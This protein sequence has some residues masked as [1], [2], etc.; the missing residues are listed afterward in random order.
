ENVAFPLRRHTQMSREEREKKARELL[1]S[2]GMED[3]IS[4]MPSEL[5]GGMQRRVGLARAL[6]LDP[7]M[8]LSDEPTAGLGP[9]TA[10]EIVDLIAEQKKKRDVTSIVVAH[11]IHSA[12]S[13]VDRMVVL[14]E[15]R[16]VVQGTYDEL[17]RSRDEFVVR[18]LREAA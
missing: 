13:F 17:G 1:A 2:V 10:S 18:Y 5:S 15:G 12:K 7:E 11:D 8:L 16:I 14:N 4:K 6:A 3:A 9:I